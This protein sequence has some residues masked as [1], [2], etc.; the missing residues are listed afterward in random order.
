MDFQ[1]LSGLSEAEAMAKIEAELKAQQ[2]VISK[3]EY[4]EKVNGLQSEI[5]SLK[6]KLEEATN[7]KTKL[8]AS[9]E[10]TTAKL[11]EFADEKLASSRLA[12][13]EKILPFEKTEKEAE[14]FVG[15]YKNLASM[16]DESFRIEKLTREIASRDKQMAVLS[17]SVS[18]AAGN[19][20]PKTQPI[21]PF[22]GETPE[23]E[24]PRSYANLL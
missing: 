3:A 10:E 2:K 16:S 6:S 1:A 14:A 4:D 21:P 17:K 7:E 5:A 9:F 22:S 15:Y 12:E 11:K 24:K 23:G 18:S 13:L 8:V 20:F 19:T